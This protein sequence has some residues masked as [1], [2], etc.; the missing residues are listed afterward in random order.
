MGM[1]SSSSSALSRSNFRSAASSQPPVVL[2]E[3]LAQLRP[4]DGLAGVEQERDEVEKAFG[5]VHGLAGAKHVDQEPGP[6][7]RATGGS[8][9][10]RA[11]FRT[12]C[13]ALQPTVFSE[14]SA[15]A[16]RCGAV[17]LGQGFPDFDGSEVVREAAVAALLQRPITS[18]RPDS[19]RWRSARPSA[20]TP[21]ASS[22]S[23]WH[24][25]T[26]AGRHCGATEAI[27]DAVQGL[28]DPGD[29]AVAFEP[30]YDSYAASV[31]MAGGV[32]RPV[33]LRPPDAGDTRAGGS[34]RARWRQRSVRAPGW[35]S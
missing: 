13:R 29:Q 27:F 35:C 23:R 12:C 6:S 7:R 26:E 10:A 15:L 34:T 22:D 20:S 25:D 16:A 28:V 32:L 18:T 30:V 4:G 19:V 24:P 3:G 2:G 9:P 5:S 31:A 21:I 1:P 14:F 8:V 17:N 11:G 33:T